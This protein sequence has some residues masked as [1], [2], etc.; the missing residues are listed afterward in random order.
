M[1][2]YVVRILPNGKLG[3]SKPCVNCTRLIKQF[4]I[5]R[6][7]YSTENGTIKTEKT[8]KLETDHVSKGVKLEKKI[9]LKSVHK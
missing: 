7:H 9:G 4:K 3:N 2:L 8:Y 1:D 6:V 5:K